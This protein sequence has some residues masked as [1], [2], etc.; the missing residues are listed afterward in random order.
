[1]LIFPGNS[2]SLYFIE[3]E[4]KVGGAEWAAVKVERMD[5]SYFIKLFLL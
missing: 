4:D 2:I 3:L 1:M 5:A